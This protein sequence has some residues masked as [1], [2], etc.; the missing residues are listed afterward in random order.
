M[1][2]LHKKGITPEDDPL[3]DWTHRLSETATKIIDMLSRIP[4][5]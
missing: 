1:K 3:M 4:A 2:D 5:E